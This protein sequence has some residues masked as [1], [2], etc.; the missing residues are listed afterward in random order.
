MAKVG[1]EMKL[2][3]SEVDAEAEKWDEYAEND[4]VKRAK[5]MSSM[6]YNMYLF[7]RGDGPLKTTHDLFT[8]AEFFAEQANQMYRT[9]REFSYEVP[10][11]AE[12]SDLSSILERIPLH[13]QQLQVLV[14]SPTVGKTAT[15]G[16][17]DSVIQETK[18]LMNEIAKLVTASFVC[19]TKSIIFSWNH[20]KIRNRVSRR[21]DQWPGAKRR[22]EGQS[23]I[24]CLATDAEHSKANP[25]RVPSLHQPRIQ[26]SHLAA[27][28]KD[29]KCLLTKP[30][31]R[32]RLTYPRP[33]RLV[34]LKLDVF[35]IP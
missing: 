19:A 29:N 35:S 27:G 5:A 22:R 12:K 11:S 28:L 2:L 33:Q 32:N 20:N 6:A 23:R 18:N 16:K 14:K 30:A 9:V 31:G 34:L 26:Y 3:T 21:H 13:C 10:G 1:L 17:V 25:A 8:Q 24:D 4:I 7:T 15:F